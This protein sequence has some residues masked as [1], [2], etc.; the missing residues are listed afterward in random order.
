FQTG[1][2][3]RWEQKTVREMVLV[4]KTLHWGDLES[5]FLWILVPVDGSSFK[6]PMQL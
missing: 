6:I 4:L 3:S 5:C 1:T 2:E